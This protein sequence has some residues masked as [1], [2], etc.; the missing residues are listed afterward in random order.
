MIIPYYLKSKLSLSN[1]N[2]CCCINNSSI[3]YIDNNLSQF[4]KTKCDLIF[5]L[6]LRFF[7]IIQIYIPDLSKKENGINNKNLDYTSL[8]IY[9]IGF[10]NKI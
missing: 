10:Q 2:I 6:L 3:L 1:K 4:K 5:C 9:F 8:Y 7:L